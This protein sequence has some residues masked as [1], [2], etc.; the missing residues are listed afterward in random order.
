MVLN[1]MTEMTMKGNAKNV[2]GTS[3]ELNKS[4]RLFVIQS[5][6]LGKSVCSGLTESKELSGTYAAV[7]KLVW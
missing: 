2:N 4:N 7:P 1:G 6:V 5:C 3:G